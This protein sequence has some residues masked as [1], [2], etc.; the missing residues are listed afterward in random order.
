MSKRKRDKIKNKRKYAAAKK[1]ALSRKQDAQEELNAIGLDLTTETF[2]A[3]IIFP[4]LS[5]SHA[6]FFCISKIN[7][8][9]QKYSGLNLQ[10]FVQHSVRCFIEPLCPINNATTLISHKHPLIATNIET[11]LEALGSQSE[12][13]CHYVFDI[14]FIRRYD[15][16]TEDL[17]RAFCDPRVMVVCRHPDHKA[18][19]EK[20]FGVSVAE[21]II[22]DFDL[23]KLIKLMTMESNNVTVS[24]V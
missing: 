19:I 3:G 13:I 22:V 16:S 7:D 9:C 4:D 5:M 21:E 2:S 18:L 14:D 11:C 12:L 23:E 20:E 1:E 6:A 15:I 24:S 10:L 8:M 17:N